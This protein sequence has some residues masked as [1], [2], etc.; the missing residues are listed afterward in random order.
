[1]ENILLELCNFNSANLRSSMFTG[2]SMTAAV[3]GWG[4]IE[5][6]SRRVV[7]PII[8]LRCWECLQVDIGRVFFI[9]FSFSR[10][11][12]WW[13]SPLLLAKG[14]AVRQSFLNA[15][16]IHGI[17]L[18]SFVTQRRLDWRPTDRHDHKCFS[19]YRFAI[20]F[21]CRT[22]LAFI[23]LSRRLFLHKT[24]TI[25]K[26]HKFYWERERKFNLSR[27][28][29]DDLL[30]TRKLTR[31][32]S[33]METTWISYRSWALSL[34]PLYFSRWV[35][36]CAHCCRRLLMLNPQQ[37]TP[38]NTAV[39]KWAASERDARS[40]SRLNRNDSP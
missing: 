35:V 32:A 14:A 27:P 1:M 24:K 30:G 2:D 11:S 10:L 34:S 40:I 5:Y 3:A 16:V 25:G 26:L 19:L 37:P 6:L 4:L 31:L 28:S 21:D 23:T 38:F 22:K 13:R 8:I 36:H 20:L 39:T 12:S 18:C 17:V 33:E 15:T 7:C 29:A 9:A